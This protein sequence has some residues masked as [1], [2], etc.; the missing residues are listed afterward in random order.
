MSTGIE[1]IK[2]NKCPLG[3][4]NPMA[5]MTCQ[6]GHMTGCHYPH[7]CDSEYC[8]HYESYEYENLD[9]DYNLHD[10]DF[11]DEEG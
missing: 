8:H 1:L 7:T 6:Y 11:E 4:T 3:L 9:D 5:C 2:Q 10:D